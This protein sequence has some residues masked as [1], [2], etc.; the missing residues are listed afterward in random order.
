MLYYL[1]SL[2]GYYVWIES[3][4]TL[5]LVLLFGSLLTSVYCVLPINAASDVVILQDTGVKITDLIGSVVSYSVFW[6][7]QNQG[8]QPMGYN[9]TGTFYNA[10]NEVIEMNYLSDSQW[11]TDLMGYGNSRH[12]V[13]DVSATSPEIPIE[14]SLPAG[15]VSADQIDHYNLEVSSFAASTF[16][17]GLEITTYGPYEEF[18]N[19]GITGQIENVGAKI[20]DEVTVMATFYGSNGELVAVASA[21]N[22]FAL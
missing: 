15:W 12:L 3:R 9:M 4:S 1:T 5:L 13:F 16:F 14:L 22:R 8:S 2:G 17:T 18:E 11:H 19:R 21:N 20:V 7:V 6:E 10:K